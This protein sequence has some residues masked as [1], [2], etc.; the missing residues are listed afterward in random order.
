MKAIGIL[1]K[2]EFI[3]NSLSARK[4]REERKENGQTKENVK[5]SVKRFKFPRI[6]KE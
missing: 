5:L 6:K 1:S 3:L 4:T 2:I